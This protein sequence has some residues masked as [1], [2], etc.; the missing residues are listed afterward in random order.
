MGTNLT[1]TG[2]TL[3][4]SSL[5]LTIVKDIKKINIICFMVYGFDIILFVEAAPIIKNS[6]LVPQCH[7]VI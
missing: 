6:N 4:G 7:S 2:G 5:Q 1:S 3:L